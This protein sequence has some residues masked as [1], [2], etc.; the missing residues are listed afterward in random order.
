[1]H[2]LLL[3]ILITIT[4]VANDALIQKALNKGLKPIPKDF[5][6]LKSQVDDENNPMTIPKILLGKKLFFDKNL[7]K[8]RS[9][10]CAKCHDIQKGGEDGKPTAI[11]YQDQE[12]PSHLNS[13]TI[14]NTAYSKHLFWDG[15]VSTL[16]EQAK[17]PIQ[18][19]FE[20]ASTPELVE[21]R[22]KEN[23]EYREKFN[24]ILVLTL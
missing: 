8:D 7:S 5:E 15:R 14:L 24:E 23:A 11:G 20:M 22:V 16:R 9:L 4:A 3:L 6:V 18:A 10:A 13:P 12:N 1:M 17:G 2:Y 21:E 19:H